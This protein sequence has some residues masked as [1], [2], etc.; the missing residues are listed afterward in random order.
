MNEQEHKL[1]LKKL[2]NCKGARYLTLF[3]INV[4]NRTSEEGFKREIFADDME[5]NDILINEA[6]KPIINE[7]Q[8]LFKNFLTNLDKSFHIDMINFD[9]EKKKK[10]R[11]VNLIYVSLLKFNGLVRYMLYQGL[12][13]ED[14]RKISCYIKH[15]FFKKGEYIFRQHEKS[16]ALYG[17][18]KGKIQIRT[19]N[20]KELTQKFHGDILKGEGFDFDDHKNLDNTIPINYFMSDVEVVNSSSESEENN[21]GYFALRKKIEKEIMENEKKEK[22]IQDKLKKNKEKIKSRKS[23]QRMKTTIFKSK[24]N[25]T[26]AQ[27]KTKKKIFLKLNTMKNLNKFDKEF[28][29]LNDNDN[30]NKNE[31]YNK[32]NF[33]RNKSN[34]KR[35][36]TTI[37]KSKIEINNNSPKKFKRINSMRKLIL[38]NDSEN[39]I[40]FEENFSDKENNNYNSK[41]KLNKSLSFRFDKNEQKN[42]TNSKR[43]INRLNTVNIKFNKNILK[44]KVKTSK[45]FKEIN[46]DNNENNLFE[47]KKEE[48]IF[49]FEQ[50]EFEK[51]NETI[52]IQ[53]ENIN[54]VENKKKFFLE[55][56]DESNDFS[57]LN[58]FKKDSISINSNSNSPINFKKRKVKFEVNIKNQENKK[59]KSNFFNLFNENNKEKEEEP[60][61]NN[62]KINKNFLHSKSIKIIEGL[63]KFQEKFFNL[64]EP[65]EEENEK[66]NNEK[67]FEFSIKK[68][69]LKKR[70]IIKSFQSQQ[71]PD[72]ITNP[73]VLFNLIEDFESKKMNLIPGY[74]FGEW[75][76]TYN[77]P[78]TTSIYC[79]EDTDVF[80]LEKKYF[81][82]FLL[83]KFHLSDLKKIQFIYDRLPI[84][85]KNS[86]N[87]DH[88]LTKITP[89]FFDEGDIVYTPYD[90]ANT[91][92]L[93]YLGECLLCEM[94]FKT[95]NKI[96]YLQK[97]DK[98][99]R[100][101]TI[102]EGGIVGL[103]S[104]LP[105]KKYEHC[106]YVVQNF[107]IL[108]KI[109]TDYF[110][111]ILEN[112]KES[113]I[114][115]YYKHKNIME[116]FHIR[117]EKVR[118]ELNFKY[119]IIKNKR[120][121]FFEE[122]YKDKEI[123][124]GKND[125]DII[126]R[127]N[128][129]RIIKISETRNIFKKK[130]K[131]HQN[132]KENE[133]KNNLKLNLKYFSSDK[134]NNKKIVDT[135]NIKIPKLLLKSPIKLEDKLFVTN[136]NTINAKESQK[137][138][139]TKNKNISFNNNVN[140][141]FD[142][143]EINSSKNI[144]KKKINLNFFRNKSIETNKRLNSRNKFFNSPI[145]NNNFDSITNFSSTKTKSNIVSA[146]FKK[147]L[148]NF[149]KINSLN[150]ASSYFNNSNVSNSI[151]YNKNNNISHKRVT[152]FDSGLFNIPFVSSLLKQ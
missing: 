136:F 91:L 36:K 135:E 41:L 95:T 65:K 133:N 45:F 10:Q 85:K 115:L 106:L 124:N 54:L 30:N 49:D 3:F 103:E 55:K 139:N 15:Q 25:I 98:L 21:E 13:K 64:E 71:T 127:I 117:N 152:S 27:N 137:N 11:K 23:F 140:E 145:K 52:F 68:S 40:N 108:L 110:Q 149:P 70:K 80:Y 72:N 7:N 151:S 24:I 50:N 12:T 114:N 109:D 53:D 33:N 31:N 131:K 96:D 134:N 92:Y 18:I 66:N 111:N 99:I 94:P 143:R 81:D 28:N 57:F 112:F 75:G 118:K 76:L 88:I 105:E 14:I 42:K 119:R 116:E 101:S 83:K 29:I 126:H 150:N 120:K 22:E 17:I 5:Y 142:S 113:L 37:V 62:K 61:K 147:K 38:N 123:I 100:V 104:C 90:K 138:I 84:L 121:Q 2:K 43:K 4:Y 89:F 67:N 69:N 144:N 102:T 9:M 1:Y 146:N 48:K 63:K 35:M 125:K 130:L 20:F 97:K 82:K 19:V 8:T 132:K 86:N 39:K 34:I 58:D 77:I 148:S 78:R 16:D 107:T 26:N 74:C 56:N 44:N 141:F 128:S 47:E 122:F 73:K 129:S 46:N 32:P 79:I 93:I 60:K 6:S 87:L 59:E 51:E